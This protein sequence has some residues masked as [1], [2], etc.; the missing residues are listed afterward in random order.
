[1]GNW[2]DDAWKYGK[3]VIP[4]VGAADEAIRAGYRMGD[5]AV[6]GRDWIAGD[7]QGRDVTSGVL[8]GAMINAGPA[9]GSGG[10][11]YA[12]P[13]G[14]DT[15]QSDQARAEMMDF[16]GALKE[17]AAGRGPS[18]A[19]D[20]LTSATDANI[21]QAMAL[22]QSQR[23]VG[24]QAGIKGMLSNQART[25]QES[26]LQSSFLRNQERM[27]AQ[28]QLGGILG[29]MRGGDISQQGSAID[30]EK[31]RQNWEVAKL[32]EA[33]RKRAATNQ[34][35]GAGLQTGGALIETGMQG[36]GKPATPAQPTNPNGP[37]ADG[38]Y[39]AASGG[40]IPGTAQAPGDS[41]RNDTVPAMLSPGEIVLPRTVAQSA[42]APDKAAEFVAAIKAQKSKA[43]AAKGDYGALV[44]KQKQ[45]QAQMAKLQA[46]LAGHA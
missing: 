15:S 41:P 38:T 32:D 9:S 33:A 11:G 2:W 23:G 29:Q 36:Q 31:V 16:V 40:Q 21:R 34:L 27:Q 17:Q 26:A 44:A 35:V 14:L 7:G 39:R 1:M 30:L 24:Y 12:P 42:D 43:P 3:W 37:D 5:N 8:G 18:A 10:S 46:Q 4:A 20:Q 25:Q 13:S 45:L 28:N 22:G 6:Q 19:Q